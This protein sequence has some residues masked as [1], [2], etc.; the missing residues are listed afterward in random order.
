MADLRPVTTDA[1]RRAAR[2]ADLLILKGGVT[3]LAE[4]TK[5]RGIWTW[6]SGESG[7]TQVLGDWYLAPG[8][9][10]PVAGAFLGQPVDSFPPAI[11]LTPMEPAPR[12]WVALSG[13]LGR[14][15]RQ[16]PAVFGRQEDRIRRVTVAV[17]GL[18]R[19]PFRGGAS[20]Q[21]YRS[22]VA[23]TASWL[24]GRFSR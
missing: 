14:R 1:V 12:D 5:A 15:G 24:P 6:P 16:R 9:A 13:Q 17:E 7:E 8:D 22:W 19:W 3:N 11:Q 21:T 18:W 20:E 4:G 10:S 23:A 2:R